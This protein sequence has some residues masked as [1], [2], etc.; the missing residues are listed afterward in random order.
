MIADVRGHWHGTGV[1]VLGKRGE[2]Y[3]SADEDGNHSDRS[4]S[5]TNFHSTARNTSF[6]ENVSSINYKH[7]KKKVES[8]CL[9][10]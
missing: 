2:V 10:T 3:E 6:N 7:L 9:K 1:S 8:R 5:I 4:N